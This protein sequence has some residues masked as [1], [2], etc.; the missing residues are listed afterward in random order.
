MVEAADEGTRGGIAPL[1]PV[2]AERRDRLHG[3]DG[4]IGENERTLPL[5][6]AE[7]LQLA[8]DDGG[9]PAA[10]DAHEEGEQEEGSFH[11]PEPARRAARGRKEGPGD[12]MDQEQQERGSRQDQNVEGLGPPWIPRAATQPPP[13]ERVARVEARGYVKSVGHGWGVGGGL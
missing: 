13:Q 8:G 3:L 4:I 12:G 6:D 10:P 7:H 1:V 2:K 5:L 9:G 11:G